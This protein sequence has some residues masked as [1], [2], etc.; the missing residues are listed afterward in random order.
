M[1]DSLKGLNIGMSEHDI[2]NIL[3]QQ[4]SSA[5]KKARK[6][7]RR[8]IIGDSSVSSDPAAHPS[9]IVS[10]PIPRKQRERNHSKRASKRGK[11]VVDKGQRGHSK[12]GTKP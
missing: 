12:A 1:L 10:I 9:T 7:R 11:A 4:S 8:D 5:V 2:D 6:V 3:N